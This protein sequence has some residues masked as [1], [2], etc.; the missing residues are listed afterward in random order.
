L[1]SVNAIGSNSIN[2]AL[3]AAKEAKAPVIVQFSQ[4][5]SQ[6][7]AGKTLDNSAQ[8]ASIAGA[9]AGAL[10]LRAVAKAY[11]GSVVLHTDHCAKKLLPWVDGV[12]AAGEE[13]FAKNGEPLFSS[14]ML[15]LSEQPIAENIEISKRYLT[16]IAKMKMTLEIELGITGGE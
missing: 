1:P 3:A 9:I 13:Y 12:I 10:H 16:R 7:V 2:A 11:G 5:G 8:Q 15:D 14:H 6:F 4:T